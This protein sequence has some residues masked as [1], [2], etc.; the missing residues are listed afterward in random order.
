MI[1]D[2]GGKMEGALGVSED[3]LKKA[4]TMAVCKINIDS[5]IRLAMTGAIRKYLNENPS[6]FDPR[7]YLKFAREHVQHMVEHKIH[8]VLGCEG[9]L[10]K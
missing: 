1:N 8:D 6:V 2:N 7:A 10:D 4:S 5:D 9:G 3:L